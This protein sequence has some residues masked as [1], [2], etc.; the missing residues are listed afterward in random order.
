MS[1]TYDDAPT[2]PE[3]RD[4]AIFISG[5]REGVQRAKEQIE[6]LYEEMQKTTRTLSLLIP[7]RQHRYLIGKGGANLMEVLETT[8]EYINVALSAH[9]LDP[10]DLCMT[11][12]SHLF[13]SLFFSIPIP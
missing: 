10:F 11:K 9:C 5:E 8:G 12:P 4:T 13:D 6:R 2:T 1:E 3:K 7:K